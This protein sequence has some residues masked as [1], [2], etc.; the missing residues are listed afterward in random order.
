MALRRAEPVVR[1][2]GRPRGL[3]LTTSI[4]VSRAAC[5]ALERQGTGN[6]APVQLFRTRH[7][8]LAF[9]SCFVAVF[10]EQRRSVRT[11]KNARGSALFELRIDKR[12]CRCEVS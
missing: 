10:L 9:R 11:R 4:D 6:R 3:R 2:H 7:E 12:E 5:Q 1:V 8:A